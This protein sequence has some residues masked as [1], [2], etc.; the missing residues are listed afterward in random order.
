MVRFFHVSIFSHFTWTKK[1][2]KLV[3]FHS[4]YQEQAGSDSEKS[5]CDS[6]VSCLIFKEQ[7]HRITEW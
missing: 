1:L 7:D 3:T 4:T 6:K 5:V 2:L